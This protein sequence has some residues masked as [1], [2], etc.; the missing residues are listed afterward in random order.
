[1]GE[2]VSHS[3]SQELQLIPMEENQVKIVIGV[4]LFLILFIPIII[5]AAQVT[6]ILDAV[7]PFTDAISTVGGGWL[8]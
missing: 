7:S 1:M 6:Q 8:G 5:A 4:L 2:V 3:G